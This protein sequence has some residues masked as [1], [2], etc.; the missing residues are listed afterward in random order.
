MYTKKERNGKF[1]K[2]I[3]LLQE[4]DFEACCL[5]GS[6]NVLVDASNPEQ[7]LPEY[8]R[9]YYLCFAKQ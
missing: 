3:I 9:S 1:T 4:Y 7:K 8:D 6:S 2:W 5:K